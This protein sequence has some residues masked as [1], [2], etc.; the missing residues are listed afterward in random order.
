MRFLLLL[1]S[2]LLLV[3]LPVDGQTNLWAGFE[4][5]TKKE[6]SLQISG[7]GKLTR[8]RDGLLWI[9]G[10]NGLFSFDGTH[11]THYRHIEGNDSSLPR[12]MVDGNYQDKAG[13]YWVIVPNEG[14]YNF[15]PRTQAF[16][17]FVYPGM[18]SFNIHR[19]RIYTLYEEG[20]NTWFVL[21]GYGLAC[22]EPKTSTMQHYRNCPLGSCG[23]YYSASWI[24]QMIKSSI[25]NSYWVASND[26]LLHFEPATSTWTIYRA[27]FLPAYDG[28]NIGNVIN[29]LY[30]DTDGLLWCGTWGRGLLRFDIRQKVFTGHYTWQAG[31]AGSRNICTGLISA[32]N[33]QL[34]VST[35]DYGFLLFDK[36]TGGFRKVRNI[37]EPEQSP[38]FV[39]TIQTGQ[40]TFWAGDKRSLYRI[41]VDT[42][43][44]KSHQILGPAERRTAPGGIYNFVRYGNKVFTG[45]YFDGA[46]GYYD[47]QRQQFIRRRIATGNAN[48]APVHLSKDN[49][50]II[51]IATDTR[52]YLYDPATDRML[53]PPVIDSSDLF[54]HATSRRT[55]HTR[56][57]SHWLATNRGLLYYDPQNHKTIVFDS[58][59]PLRHRIPSQWVYEIFE[60]AKDRIWIGTIS[61]GVYCYQP[62][63]DSL[64]NIRLQPNLLNEKCIAIREDHE[65]NILYALENTGLVLLEHPLTPQQRTTLL[66][67]SN[68][69]PTDNI[70]KIHIDRKGR[71]WLN[72]EEGLL[73]FDVHTRKYIAFRREDGLWDES[74][75][76]RPYEDSTG[77]MYVGF[78]HGFQTFHPD[79]LLQHT[80]EPVHIRMNS[81]TVDGKQQ[82][83]PPA[84]QSSITIEPELNN[85]SFTF[86]AISPSMA[87]HFQ[88]AYRLEGFDK[89]WHLPG[90]TGLG[91]YNYLPPGHYR[92][93]IKAAAINGPW[94]SDTF[95]IPFIV[96]PAWYQAT[97]FRL[98]VAALLA[99]LVYALFRYRLKT[100]RQEARFKENYHKRIKELEIRSLRAQMNP[101]FI[102]NSLSS[103]NRY[104]VKSDHKMAS[105]YLT[106]FSRLI[107]QILDNSAA[108][109]ISLETEL[110]TLELYIEME[111]LRFDQA[112]TYEIIIDE[113]IHPADTYI[114][115]MLLQPYVENAIWHGLL[116]RDDGKGKLTITLRYNSAA[117]LEARIEDNGI[118]RQK[119]MEMKSRE[120]I[121]TKSYGMQLSLDRLQLLNQQPSG[122][123]PVVIDDLTN[124]TGE[125]SGTRV[126][127]YIPIQNITT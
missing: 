12:N 104:I 88:Y 57:G 93:H 4:T 115:P 56:A 92:L 60:D 51:W 22:W 124:A 59:Q 126:I 66:N 48:D 32:S 5:Y 17:R 64:I 94:E 127:L 100:V 23:T 39:S 73:Q 58:L 78:K 69:L 90:R 1:Y 35:L 72:T 68:V 21:P 102:F 105:N 80:R 26:G 19:Q 101:H 125:A 118:G 53:T 24:T 112:F 121:R 15:D 103:I 40:Y 98:L 31:I 52:T 50:G 46:F 49:N 99:G 76:S 28:K 55:F 25:D 37:E 106:R 87:Q 97:W 27:P 42:T 34:W 13:R 67:S 20:D 120:A 62:Q 41:N 116:H 54:F 74:I 122:H 81:I 2:C 7:P 14:L 61:D 117:L 29:H 110:E 82:L 108:D 9:A 84:F 111:K 83:P 75:I 71:I 16:H 107:R 18:D 47:L 30:M 63:K 119:A 123:S 36:A 38:G 91:Q 33:G 79:S 95:S 45:A 3:V 89:D 44:F 86:A 6:R 10:D 77:L 109:S 43:R 114:P 65:G 11:F 113:Q 70:G 85:I 8:D 96:L